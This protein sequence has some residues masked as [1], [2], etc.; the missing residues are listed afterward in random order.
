VQDGSQSC[1]G[2]EFDLVANPVSGLNL[3]LGYAHNN[4]IQTRIAESLLGRRPTSA[5]PADLANFWASYSF[6]QGSL[7]GL[8]FGF[9]GNYAGENKITNNSITGEFTLPAYTVLNSSLFYSANTYRISLKVDNLANERYFG[10]WSTVEPQ[11]PR[12]IMASL[13]F[14]F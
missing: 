13:A 1:K 9:G 11:M 14:Q 8:G 2:V 7:K 12:R 5:G 4:S 10:G 3:V 6:Q